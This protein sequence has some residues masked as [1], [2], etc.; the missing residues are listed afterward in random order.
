[1]VC[2]HSNKEENIEICKLE[3]KNQKFKQNYKAK[4]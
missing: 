3:N 1:M 4:I 2:R